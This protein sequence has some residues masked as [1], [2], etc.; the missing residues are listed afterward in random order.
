MNIVFL[1]AVVSSSM[2]NPGTLNAPAEG[3]QVAMMCF[4]SGEQVSGMNKI[5]FYNCGGSAKAVTVGAAELCPL[6]VDD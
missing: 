3:P 1:A 6:S 2:A 5:C 4:K